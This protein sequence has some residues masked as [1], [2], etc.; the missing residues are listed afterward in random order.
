M[1]RSASV[2]EIL[3][4]CKR[5]ENPANKEKKYDWKKIR[6]FIKDNKENIAEVSVGMEEDWFWTGN[7]VWE[8]GKWVRGFERGN[9]DVG[10]I[11]GSIWATPIMLVIFKDGTDEEIEA[12][13]WDE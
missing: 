10:G 9:P 7:T 8:N 6:Q 4:G 1:I 11:D 5:R 3:A 12:W 2:S 13:K